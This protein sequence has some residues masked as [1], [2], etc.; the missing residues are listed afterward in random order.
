MKLCLFVWFLHLLLYLSWF[1]GSANSINGCVT[2]CGTTEIPYPFGIGKGCSASGFEVSCNEKSPSPVPS[3]FGTQFQILN[4]SNGELQ[5]DSTSYIATDCAHQINH[6]LAHITL[7]KEGPFTV[8]DASNSFMAIGCDTVAVISDDNSVTSGCVSLCTTQSSVANGSCSGAG[9]CE[10]AIPKRAR[11]LTLGASSMFG[12]RNVSSFSNCSYAFVVKRESFTFVEHKL[13]DFLETAD[14]ALTLDWAVGDLNCS[15]ASSLACGGNSSCIDSKRGFGYLCNC[16]DGYAGN[17]YLNGSGGCQDIDECLDSELNP[18]VSEAQCH[19]EV[20]GYACVCPFGSTGDGTRRGSGCRKYFQILEAVLGTTLGFVIM[21]LCSMWFYCA[22]KKR[23]LIKLKEQYFRQNGGLLLKQQVSTREGAD[24]A[25]IFSSEQLKQ[26]TQN[27]DESR[28]LGSGGYGTVY[29]GNL[30]DGTTVA[31]KKSKVMDQ[32]QI[33]QFINEVVILTQINHRNVVKL[34]GC[35]LET[36]VPMLV[37]EFI[38]NGTLHEHIHEKQSKTEISWPYRLRIATE[39]AEA[40]AYLHSAASMP[41]FHRDVKSSNILLDEHYTAKVADFGISRLVPMDQSQIPTL[42]QG[43]LGYLD[44]EYFQTSQLT[45]K[46]DVYSFGVVLVELLTGQRPVSYERSHENSNLAMYFL[47]S[48]K[49]KDLKEFLDESVM[50]EGGAEQLRAVAELARKC[51][52]LKGDKRPT[53]KEV[54]QELVRIADF[55]RQIRADDEE[56]VEDVGSNRCLKVTD[57]EDVTH[58][59]LSLTY[60]FAR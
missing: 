18:C 7:P 10:S 4:I 11:Y 57:G 3:L 26:A 49:G 21:F 31:I 19:N 15:T 41:I 58:A 12:Y 20:P 2:K 59:N 22:L 43:T 46:S 25:R 47:S 28:I 27:Y 16:S 42:V 32:N 38:P 53:M 30:E 14:I 52:L 34:L 44:P 24:C 45:E 55:G 60:D 50:R 13:Q 48:L 37:Y 40:L 23:T 1:S 39:T 54:A 17:P 9:C 5:I 33:D 35:C 56:T 8:S 51:L 36:E 29:K 6:T